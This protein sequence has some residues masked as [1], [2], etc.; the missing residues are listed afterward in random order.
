MTNE[1]DFDSNGNQITSNT[2]H[3]YSLYS[4]KR[5]VKAAHL[6]MQSEEIK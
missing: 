1:D 4:D 5:P 3:P 6:K 2:T